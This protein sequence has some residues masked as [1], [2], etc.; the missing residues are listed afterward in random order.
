MQTGNNL[1]Q[2]GILIEKF[3]INLNDFFFFFYDLES[4]FFFQTF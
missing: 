1:N 4:K 2:I 3:K